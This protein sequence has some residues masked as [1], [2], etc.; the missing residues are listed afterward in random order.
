MGTG[1]ISR[2]AV[3][4]GTERRASWHDRAIVVIGLGVELLRLEDVRRHLAERGPA[5]VEATWTSAE[6]DACLTRA[7]PAP[8]LAARLAA[9]TAALNAL[10]L[11]GG[12]PGDVEVV[13]RESGKPDLALHGAARDA[14][15]RLGADSLHVT[16]THGESHVLALVILEATRT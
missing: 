15:A 11:D 2:A 16:L 14:A 7:D 1:L 9:K 4:E 13:R 5:W 10:G 6:R 8:G 3:R 12:T